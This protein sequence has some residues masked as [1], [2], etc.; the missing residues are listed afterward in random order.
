MANNLSEESELIA[1]KSFSLLITFDQLILKSLFRSMVLVTILL[2]R[3][4]IVS[5]EVV[6]DTRANL[7]NISGVVLFGITT[8]FLKFYLMSGP[9]VLIFFAIID[10]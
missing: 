10:D 4:L 8:Y 5:S 2:N 9:L 3:G 7:E 6:G 1:Y